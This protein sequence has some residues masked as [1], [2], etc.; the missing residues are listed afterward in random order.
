MAP[1]SIDEL[2]RIITPI[3][4]AHGVKSV[5]LFGSYSRGEASADSDV[6]SIHGKLPGSH[7]EIRL[8]T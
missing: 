6:E 7:V 2:R 3:A 4:H 1:Y 8:E 5:S